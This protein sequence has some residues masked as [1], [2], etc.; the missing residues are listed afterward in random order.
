MPRGIRA[1][2]AERGR[3]ID[4]LAVHGEVDEVLEFSFSEPTADEPQAD[5]GLLATLP[6]VEFVEGEAKLPVLEYEV[7][8]RVVVSASRSVH[9]QA[10]PVD[11]RHHMRLSFVGWRTARFLSPRGQTGATMRR[12]ATPEVRWPA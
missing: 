11:R 8:A 2:P 7:L 1:G 10:V 5:R 3:R 6:E 4:D 9:E 12:A